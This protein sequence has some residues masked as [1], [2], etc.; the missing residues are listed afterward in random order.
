[1]ANASSCL[2][3]GMGYTGEA[4]ASGLSKQGVS[5]TGW[6][7]SLESAARLQANGWPVV[8]GEAADPAAWQRA[9]AT[10]AIEAAPE[11][12]VYSAAPS[13]GGGVENY[14]AVYV[15]ALHET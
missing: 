1:M 14:R 12:L 4:L 9:R 11:W 10:G 13:S 5:V 15:A 3:V 7:R 2:I 8:S 6:V